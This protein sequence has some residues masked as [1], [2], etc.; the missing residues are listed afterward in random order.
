MNALRKY[1]V[2]KHLIL[3]NHVIISCW[4]FLLDCWPCPV[5]GDQMSMCILKIDIGQRQ[6]SG[7][8]GQFQNLA[9]K[10]GVVS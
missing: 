4:L 9:D 8:V 7:G 2:K 1:C 5:S 10:G 6:Q 3:T